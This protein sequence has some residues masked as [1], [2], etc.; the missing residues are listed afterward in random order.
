[1]RSPGNTSAGI[2]AKV[3]AYLAHGVREVALI[4]IDASVSYVTNLGSAATS[5][6]GVILVVPDGLSL[7]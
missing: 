2:A 7:G 3:A 1:V 5:A 6:L 4:E